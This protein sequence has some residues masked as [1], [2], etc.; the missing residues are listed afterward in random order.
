MSRQLHRQRER[1]RPSP[2]LGQGDFI[3]YQIEVV[4]ADV[5]LDVTLCWTDYPPNPAADVQLVNNLNL[6]VSKGATVYRGNVYTGGVS[7]TGAAAPTGQFQGVA[8]STN[9]WNQGIVIDNGGTLR[10]ITEA[11]LQQTISDAERINNANVELMLS[12]QAAYDAYVALL[13]IDKRYVNTTELK[14]GHTTLSFNGMPW[15]KD[16]HCYQNRVYFLAL[17]QVEIAVTQEL[18]A[19]QI[20]DE[21]IWHQVPNYDKWYRGWVRDDQLLVSGIRNR[22]GALLSDL[23]A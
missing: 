10:P 15:V 3:E 1:S 11:L 22:C 17:D 21:T 19:L 20:E 12:H 4:S 7:V 14:G 13:T 5:P 2:G 6:T 8:C 16:R 9:L 18:T 23:S